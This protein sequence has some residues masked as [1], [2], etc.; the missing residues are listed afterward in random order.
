MGDIREVFVTDQSSRSMRAIECAWVRGG[1]M[2]SA[3]SWSST[4]EVGFLSCRSSMSLQSRDFGSDAP[5][6]DLSVCRYYTSY[7]SRHLRTMHAVTI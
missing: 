1:P 4:I 2:M 5:I 3:Q 6:G 7:P